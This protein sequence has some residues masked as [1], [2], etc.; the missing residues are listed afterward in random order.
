MGPFCLEGQCIYCQVALAVTS[1]IF[2][3]FYRLDIYD[4]KAIKSD[5]TI[6][7]TLHTTC[8]EMVNRINCFNALLHS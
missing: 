3:F 2:Q 1:I 6:Q 5:K 8:G 7:L 4:E